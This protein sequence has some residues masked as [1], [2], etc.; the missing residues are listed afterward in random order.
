MARTILSVILGFALMAAMTHAAEDAS[1]KESDLAGMYACEGTNPNGSPYTA[2]VEIVRL[3]KTYLVKWIQP[4]GSEVLGVG[5]QRGSMFSVSYFGS[6]PAIV[7]Y[8]VEADGKMDGQ[9]TM[10][11]AEG[12]VFTETLTKL[13]VIASPSSPSSPRPPRPSRRPAPSRTLTI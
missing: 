7:V 5:L 12:S 1:P 4:N 10:G 13:K 3:E 8:S 11:G 9:W 2:L 6:A